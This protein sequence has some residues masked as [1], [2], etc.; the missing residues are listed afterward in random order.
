MHYKDVKKNYKN[1][2][3]GGKKQGLYHIKS[4]FNP[5]TAMK[6]LLVDVIHLKNIPE[7]PSKEIRIK[8]S[9]VYKHQNYKKWHNTTKLYNALNPVVIY[10]TE[11]EVSKEIT[12]FL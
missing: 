8:H 2:I 3:V 7:F 10:A 12:Q 5:L 1:Y 4:E 6:Q 9:R 11:I